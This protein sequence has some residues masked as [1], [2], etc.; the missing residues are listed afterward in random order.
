MTWNE[1]PIRAVRVKR[2]RGHN[3]HRIARWGIRCME[4]GVDM[5]DRIGEPNPV[6]GLT[7]APGLPQ[8]WVLGGFR[9]WHLPTTRM[10]ARMLH[11]GQK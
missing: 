8:K 11:G 10:R 4:A 7:G 5:L 2:T 6:V 1:V 9:C 3:G